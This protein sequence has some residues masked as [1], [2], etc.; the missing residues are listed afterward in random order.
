MHRY[1][2]TVIVCL[3]VSGGLAAGQASPGP[4]A[5][6]GALSILALPVSAGSSSTGSPSPSAAGIPTGSDV[7]VWQISFDIYVPIGDTVFP[8]CVVK[9]F[10]SQTQTDVPVVCIIYNTTA[11]VPAYGPETVYVANIKANVVLTVKFPPWVPPARELV[12]LDTMATA[13]PGDENPEN[14]LKAGRLTVSDW[15]NGHPVYLDGTFENAI[16]WVESGGELTATFAPPL[17]ALTIDKAVLWV[18]SWTRDDYDAEVRIRANDGSPHGYPGTQLGAWV[19]ELHTD[20]WPLLCRNEVR[21]DPPVK[22]DSDTLFI[23]YYQTS[24]FPGYPFLGLDASTPV[25]RGNDWIR[26]PGPRQWW[27]SDYDPGADF[28]VDVYY[29]AAQHDGS[30]KG[31]TIPAA[32]VDSN[33][34]FAP[35]V[36]VRNCGLADLSGIPAT[37]CII[38]N[39]GLGDTVY[40]GFAN[41]GPVESGQ[42]KA[43]TFADA[44]KLDPGDYT[45]TSITRVPLD[46]RPSNDTL[47]RQLIVGR[48]GALARDVA[49]GRSH[50]WITPNPLGGLATVRYI[51]TRAGPVTLDVYDVTGRT[52][53]TQ[54]IAAALTGT[55]TLDLRGFKAGVYLVKVTTESFSTTQKLVVQH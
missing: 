19:G 50:F 43:V 11:D 25:E 52:V 8:S 29:T 27:L 32:W 16:S 44:T 55:A 5:A 13:L 2:L 23:C 38:R 46:A 34:T 33:M 48:E 47:V 45:M 1:G 22:V 6:S 51:L 20:S 37:F 12:Y 42:T 53:L 3:L 21:F 18:A 40:A 35:Q 54:T 28:G 14:D 26:Y 41:S 15:G 24:V 36:V 9:N 39:S 4:G 7:G 17:S 49:I 30:T 10:G 31:I